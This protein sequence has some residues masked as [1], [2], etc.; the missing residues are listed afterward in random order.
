M[1][2]VEKPL[3]F[4]ASPYS[5][6]NVE[7]MESR[8]KRVSKVAAQLVSVGNLVYCPIAHTHPMAKYGHMDAADYK[9]WKELNDFYLIR[10]DILA[11]LTL[12]G[13]EQSAGVKAEIQMATEQGK[14]IIYLPAIKLTGGI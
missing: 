3:I 6:P 5:A 13:W 11:I 7:E 12:P 1:S 10:C 14:P 2:L 4:L 9:I 8:Y